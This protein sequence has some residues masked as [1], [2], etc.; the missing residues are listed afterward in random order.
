[1]LCVS[2]HSARGQVC[3][4]DSARRSRTVFTFSPSKLLFNHVLE[5]PPIAV[6]TPVLPVALQGAQFFEIHPLLSARRSVRVTQTHTR[7]KAVTDAVCKK[8][9]RRIGTSTHLKSDPVYILEGG[10]S[11]GVIN[12]ASVIGSKVYKS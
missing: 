5:V 2:Y 11:S 10:V 12:I 1:M 9:V 4:S 7:A 6:V 3:T 8:K